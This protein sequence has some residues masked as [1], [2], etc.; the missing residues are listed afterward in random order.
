[1]GLPDALIFFSCGAQRD[2][3]PCRRQL[4]AAQTAPSLLLMP[5]QQKP[6]SSAHSRLGLSTVPARLRAERDD[7]AG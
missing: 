4:D 5:S 7:P 2:G 1:M 3:Q 6:A